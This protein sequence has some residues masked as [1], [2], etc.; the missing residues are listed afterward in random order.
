MHGLAREQ[1]LLQG[2]LLL[3]HALIDSRLAVPDELLCRVRVLKVDG[4][5]V[6]GCRYG[7]FFG[8]R[9]ALPCS[10]EG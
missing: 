7:G 4:I 3:L 6:V 2:A 1:E 9:H 5:D 8:H 10:V